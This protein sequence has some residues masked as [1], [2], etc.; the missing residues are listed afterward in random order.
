M[1]ALL[2]HRPA[3]AAVIDVEITFPSRSIPPLTAY[4]LEIDTR[5]MQSAT[6]AED[7]NRFAIEV[8]AGRYVVFLAPREPGAPSIYGA[9]TQFSECMSRNTVVDP[10]V[11]ACDDHELLPV[12]VKSPAA[13]ARVRIDDWYLSDKTSAWIDDALGVVTA[14]GAFPLG[15][16]RFSEYPVPVQIVIAPRLELVENAAAP[17]ERAK[18]QQALAGGPNFAAT[19]TA[20]LMR[21]GEDCARLLLVDWRSGKI[22]EPQ[23]IPELKGALPCR[24]DEALLS[25]RDSLLL[26]VAHAA[27]AVVSIRFYLWKPQAETLALAGDYQVAEQQFCAGAPLA[28]GIVR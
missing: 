5:H 11:A 9:Y 6:V 23:G 16:P 17:E 7:Q 2:I 18:L 25:R 26:S 13:H 12:T 27:D 22:I 21:C 20:T 1:A 14:A 3:A 4:A 8:P 28:N 24:N 10:A 19:L 15:A